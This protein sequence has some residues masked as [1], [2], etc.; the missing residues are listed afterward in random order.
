MIKCSSGHAESWH[1]WDNKRMVPDGGFTG[2]TGTRGGG[3]N[4]NQ[5]ALSP[6][7]DGQDTSASTP[8]NIDFLSQGFKIREDHDLLNGS[9]DT[10]VY[11]AFAELPFKFSNAD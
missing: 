1:I 7:T 9:G 5:A 8:Y 3:G 2:D 10:Y 6:N 4:P 11:W